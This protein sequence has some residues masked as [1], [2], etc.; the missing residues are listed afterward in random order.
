MR[1]SHSRAIHTCETFHNPAVEASD[2]SPKIHT[3]EK[4]HAHG[5]GTSDPS[6]E[7]VEFPFHNHSH[8][9]KI[10]HH[11]SNRNPKQPHMGKF[12]ISE[13]TNQYLSPAHI[14]ALKAVQIIPYSN[15]YEK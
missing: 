10:S 8:W 7:N 11:N 1:T 12:C 15:I 3:S 14:A 9:C 4:I 13:P 5:V 6:Y 2:Q